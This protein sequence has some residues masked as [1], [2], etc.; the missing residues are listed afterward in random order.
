M[1][2]DLYTCSDLVTFL[3]SITPS[4]KR[5]AVQDKRRIKK[6]ICQS[7]YYEDMACL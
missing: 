4:L 3:S 6:A 5:N 2:D 7:T 1:L